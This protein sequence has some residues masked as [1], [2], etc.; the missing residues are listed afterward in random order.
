MITEKDIAF[1]RHAIILARDGVVSGKGGPFGCVIVKD[2]R[3]IGKGCNEV[4]SA[5]D[6]TAHA[7]VVAIR[8]ACR[9]LGGYQLSGCDVYTSCEPCPMCLG[10]LYWARPRKVVY[11]ASRHEAA[12]AGFDDE[13]IYKEINLAMPER[14]IP[15]AYEGLPEARELFRLWMEKGNK[16]LY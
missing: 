8:D 4:T 1:L 2:G 13:F 10:A 9:Q 14:K 6:P 5:N 16:K 7:E 3:V 11:A 12:A 15:F